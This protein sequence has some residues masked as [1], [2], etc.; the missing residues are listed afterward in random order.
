MAVT[1]SVIS[2]WWRS[3]GILCFWRDTAYDN[4]RFLPCETDVHA[5]NQRAGIDRSVSDGARAVAQIDAEEKLWSLLSLMS[6]CWCPK[7]RKPLA[8]A[9]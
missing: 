5:L 6:P 2:G 9:R 1:R 8:P 4:T 7:A 3:T